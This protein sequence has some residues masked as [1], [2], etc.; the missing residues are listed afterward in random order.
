MAFQTISA[1]APKAVTT[2]R[3]PVR[4][5]RR[6]EDFRTPYLGAFT[7]APYLKR[8]PNG[9]PRSTLSGYQAAPDLTSFPNGQP[10]SNI[11]GTPKEQLVVLAFDR[12]MSKK[13]CSAFSNRSRGMRGLGDDGDDQDV[14][15]IY[16][17]VSQINANVDTGI[18]GNADQYGY[19][20]DT[21]TLSPSGTMSPMSSIAGAPMVNVP[22]TSPTSIG[23]SIANA[24][25][26][27][28][29]RPTTT[30]YYSPYSPFGTAGL[31]AP[32][33]AGSST[34]WG[35]VLLLG[36]GALLLVMALKKR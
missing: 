12:A 2:I 30:G 11:G 25:G 21:Q 18:T 23:S 4:A 1:V 27:I 34:T 33:A 10:M 3:G 22:I 9:Q 29:G 14:Q 19:G 16:D 7:K 32:I 26:S 20:I 36:G 8:F 15:D 31:A 5:R 28:F 6:P 35:S 24:I 13:G 17:S